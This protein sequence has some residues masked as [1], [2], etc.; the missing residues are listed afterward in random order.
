[1]KWMYAVSFAVSAASA[2]WKEDVRWRRRAG[3]LTSAGEVGQRDGSSW[4]GKGPHLIDKFD[5]GT[6]L[7]LTAG[8]RGTRASP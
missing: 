8:A 5:G 6:L 1:M 3:G 2:V 4:T 7:L